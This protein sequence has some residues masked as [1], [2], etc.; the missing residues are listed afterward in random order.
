MKICKSCNLSKPFSDF[1]KHSR[2]SD[3][4]QSYCKVC[5]TK[6]NKE[7]TNRNKDKQA[8]IY[9]RHSLKRSYGMTLDEHSRL[10]DDQGYCCGIC[11]SKLNLSAK[12]GVNVD[13]DHS[14]GAVRGILCNLC[15]TALGSFKDS[16]GILENAIAYLKVNGSYGGK[17]GSN[18]RA[19]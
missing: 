8:V 19:A 15:N 9:K 7:W 18:S 3:G 13:H 6:R 5:H 16:V 4:L 12:N 2:Q 10:L 11:G 1:Y 14:T 17:D